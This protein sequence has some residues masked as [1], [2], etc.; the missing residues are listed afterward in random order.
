M[1]GT[2]E[3]DLSDE[4][5]AFILPLLPPGRVRRTSRGRMRADRVMFAVV[6]FILIRDQPWTAGAEYGVPA[7]TVQRQWV[8]WH[9]TRVFERM[10]ATADGRTATRQWALLVA[11]TSDQRAA[12]YGYGP[13]AIPQFAS[14]AGPSD[15]DHRRAWQLQNAFP[16][17]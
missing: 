10:A 17:S 12:R 13:A 2:H 5:W 6:A 15:D 11:R 4:Q 14:V 7:R 8:E 16:E 3:R 1:S 9:H